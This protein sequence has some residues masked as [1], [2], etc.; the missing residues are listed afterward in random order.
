M[1]IKTLESP[2]SNSYLEIKTNEKK[3]CINFL[4]LPPLSAA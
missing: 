3:E 2:Q 1:F 4:L